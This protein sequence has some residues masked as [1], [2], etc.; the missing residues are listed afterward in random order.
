M[1]HCMM[2]LIADFFKKNHYPPVMNLFRVC[3]Y[4]LESGCLCVRVSHLCPEDLFQTTKLYAAKLG[5]MLHHH[6]PCLILQ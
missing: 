5:M 3:E 4:I 6:G 1:A 2:R